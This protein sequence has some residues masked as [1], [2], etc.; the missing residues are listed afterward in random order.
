MQHAFEKAKE[1]A[2]KANHRTA[3]A[4]IKSNIFERALLP[5]AKL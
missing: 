1:W 3:M 4:V 2:P 5:A